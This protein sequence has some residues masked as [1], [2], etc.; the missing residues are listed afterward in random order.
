MT[1]KEIEEKIKENIKFAKG[2]SYNLWRTRYRD[3]L[4]LEDVESA[5]FEGLWNGIVT[6]DEGGGTQFR[7][8]IRRKIIW[9]VKD[10]S[11]YMKTKDRSFLL[12]DLVVGFG[13]NLPGM[14]TRTYEDVL[15]YEDFH[16]IDYDFVGNK[17]HG[18][19]FLSKKQ[20]ERWVQIKELV[21]EYEGHL[22]LKDLSEKL[23]L[24]RQGIHQLL[25]KLS[26][27][28][29][30]IYNPGSKGEKIRILEKRG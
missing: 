1:E 7:N 6:F 18:D 3:H 26:E 5:A 12:K 16:E 24:T 9:Y 30:I 14:T 28:G 17:A 4:L 20:R 15:G 25:V 13:D 27:K 19:E 8:W 22:S 23:S 11:R 21:I 10:C 2:I 29:A